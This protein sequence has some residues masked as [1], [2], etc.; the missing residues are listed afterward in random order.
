MSRYHAASDTIAVPAKTNKGLDVLVYAHESG[1]RGSVSVREPKTGRA[2]GYL[3]FSDV[4]DGW[5]YAKDVWVDKGNHRK[6][7]ASLMY[8]WVE[9]NMGHQLLPSDDQTEDAVAFWTN[10]IGPYD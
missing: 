8:D 3:N 4:G 5:H 6:G 7:V 10:R 2:V 1:G 9:D